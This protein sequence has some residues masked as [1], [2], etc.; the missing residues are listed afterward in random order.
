MRASRGVMKGPMI[1]DRSSGTQCRT[2]LALIAEDNPTLLGVLEQV[3][4]DEG[5]ATATARS[6]ATARDRLAATRPDVAIV[7]LT[8]LDGFAEAL[9]PDLNEAGVPTVIL[10]T[11]PLARR[12]A[13]RHGVEV[14][15]KPFDLTKL[16]AAVHRAR[17]RRQITSQS[18]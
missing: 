8:L 5:Y 7:D 13:E 1:D 11:F 6:I 17:E 14:V 15:T 12:I 18:A 4:D 16:L 9:L 3:L 10:S 2:G